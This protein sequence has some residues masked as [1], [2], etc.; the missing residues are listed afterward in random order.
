MSL[1]LLLRS[2]QALMHPQ[3]LRQSKCCC[4]CPSAGAMCWRQPTR[5]AADLKVGQNSNSIGPAVACTSF[6]LSFCRTQ[7]HNSSRRVKGLTTQ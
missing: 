4:V 1:R 6:R 7:N 3:L 5:P 2:N